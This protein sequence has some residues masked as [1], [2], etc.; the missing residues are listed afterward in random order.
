MWS[1]W[2]SLLKYQSKDWSKKFPQFFDGRWK[3]EE[4]KHGSKSNNK[5]MMLM[6]WDLNCNSNY[7]NN[8]VRT[9]HTKLKWRTCYLGRTATKRL[10]ERCDWFGCCSE[11]RH[12]WRMWLMYHLRSSLTSLLMLMYMERLTKYSNKLWTPVLA[13][14][15]QKTW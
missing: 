12:V 1:Q 3:R 11:H 4:T 6:V 13:L 15:Q 10:S 8:Y 2:L 7:R 9:L 14:M 5:V